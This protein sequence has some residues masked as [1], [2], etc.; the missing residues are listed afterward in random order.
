MH[1]LSPVHPG[2]PT[3]AAP[4]V[5]SRTSQEW[6]TAH[7]GAVDGFNIDWELRL[8]L[9]VP[10]QAAARAGTWLMGSFTHYCGCA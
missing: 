9:A 3:R 7:P 10:E 1:Y 8:D 2:S 4:A 6:A 5:A